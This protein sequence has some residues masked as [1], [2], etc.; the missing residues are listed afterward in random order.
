[1]TELEALLLKQLENLNNSFTEQMNELKEITQKENESLRGQMRLLEKDVQNMQKHYARL[2]QTLGLSPN[3]QCNGENALAESLVLLQKLLT[4]RQSS[5]EHELKALEQREN[6][7]REQ[8]RHLIM[9]SKEITSQQEKLQM[10][11]THYSELAQRLQNT[12]KP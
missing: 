8:Q 2:L 6:K 7:H 10:Q 11:Q 12:L 5:L 9:Q 4:E 1:M 3:L